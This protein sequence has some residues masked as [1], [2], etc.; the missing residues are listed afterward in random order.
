MY[1]VSHEGLSKQITR[2]EKYVWTA[3]CGISKEEM[4]K[5]W[6]EQCKEYIR[7]YNYKYLGVKRFINTNAR[8]VLKEGEITN[9]RGRI[10]HLPWYNASRTMGMEFRWLEGRAARQ[11]V[12][13]LVQGEAADLFKLATVRVAKVLEGY[14]SRINNVIH[15]D[16]VMYIHRD[17]LFLLPLIKEAMED[18]PEYSVPILA[19]FEYSPLCWGLKKKV[20]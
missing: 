15:D 8:I 20:G 18:F 3:D 5:N 2:P 7:Q 16:I 6:V 11:G 13:Y 17:E 14:K 12:N 19:S 9:L 4:T 10:R 1:G